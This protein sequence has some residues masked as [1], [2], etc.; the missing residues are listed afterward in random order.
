MTMAKTHINIWLWSVSLYSGWKIL[1]GQHLSNCGR[2]NHSFGHSWI[3]VL[4]I[5]LLFREITFVAN[6]W[7]VVCACTCIESICN[8]Y[9]AVSQ[10]NGHWCTHAWIYNVVLAYYIQI[11]ACQVAW[12]SM[13]WSSHIGVLRHKDVSQ[14]ISEVD[15]LKKCDWVT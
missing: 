14:S 7:R 13:K 1:D 5:A 4:D 8:T 15:Y 9:F 12:T 10:A 3:H 2:P 11:W 6:L